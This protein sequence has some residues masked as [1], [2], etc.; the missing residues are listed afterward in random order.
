MWETHGP[1]RHVATPRIFPIL[2]ACWRLEWYVST[3]PPIFMGKIIVKFM[4]YQHIVYDLPTRDKRRLR[5]QND[6]AKERLQTISYSFRGYFIH[7]ITQ[8]NGPKIRNPLGIGT[9][10]QQYDMSMIKKSCIHFIRN[11]WLRVSIATDSLVRRLFKARY[12]S[13]TTLVDTVGKGSILYAWRSILSAKPVLRVGCRWGIVDGSSIQIANSPW[14][15]R[16]TMFRLVLPLL[17]LDTDVMVDV[18]LDDDGRW[19]E[20]MVRS[21]FN[22]L[23]A[24]WILNTPTHAGEADRL[25]LHYNKKGK[26]SVRS[27]YWFASHSATMGTSSQWEEGAIWD[28]WGFYGGRKMPLRLFSSRGSADMLPFPPSITSAVGGWKWMEFVLWNT[29]W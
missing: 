2:S 20:E 18:L 28:V 5:L 8:A 3:R 4:S 10:R 14:I 17:S 15:L 22:P 6:I 9:L 21:E 12:C 26:F 19:D 25:L 7:D 24:E 27:A 23:D 1:P 16:P 11:P 29:S 13:G